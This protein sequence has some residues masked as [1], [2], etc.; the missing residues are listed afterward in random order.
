MKRITSLLLTICL[1]VCTFNMC[2][3]ADGYGDSFG[4]VDDTLPDIIE[5]DFDPA[6]AVGYNDFESISGFTS[7]SGFVLEDCGNSAY[8]KALR[9]SAQGWG[10]PSNILNATY[11]WNGKTQKVFN[12]TITSGE[13]YILS[14]EYWSDPD[15]QPVEIGDK[16][17]NPSFVIGGPFS[18]APQHANLSNGSGDHLDIPPYFNDNKWHVNTF[19]FTADATTVKGKINSCATYTKSYFDN[20]LLMKAGE[21]KIND[22]TNT[23]Y[24]EP[25]KGDIFVQNNAKAYNKKNTAALGSEI[26]FKLPARNL[27]VNV[28]EVKMGNAV[29]TPDK[30]GVYNVKITDD[31]V[32]NVE[33]DISFITDKF[34]VDD[35]NNIY[36]SDKESTISFINAVN[37]AFNMFDVIR[38]DE[39]PAK[40]TWLTANDKLRLNLINESYNVKYIGDVA[41]GGDGEWTVSDVLST[42]SNILGTEETELSEASFDMNKTGRTTVSDVVA[43]RS[44]ILNVPK[45]LTPDAELIDTMDAFFQDVLTRSGTGATEQDLINGIYN[46]GDRTRIANV[47]RKAMRGEQI[48]V[49]YFGGSITNTSGGSSVAPFANSITETGGYVEWITRWFKKHFGENSIDAFNA[50]IGSTDT[51]LAIHRMVEDVLEKEPDLVINEWSMNDSA[52]SAFAYKQG[53]YEAVVKRLLENDIAVLLYGFAGSSGYTSEEVHKPVADYYSVPFVSEK[54]A[55]YH[56]SNFSKFTNDDVHPNMVGHALTGINMTYFLQKVYEEINVIGTEPLKLPDIYFHSEAHRYEGAYMVDLYDAYQAGEE[57][58]NGVVIKDMG[59]FEFDTTKTS[60]GIGG[61]RSYYGA[62]AKLAASYKPMVIEIKSAKTL[63]LLTRIFS[64]IEDGGYY[65]E[66]NG[67]KMTN[68]EY[69]CSKGKKQDTN[70]EAGYHW[71]TPLIMYDA[72]SPSVE[73]KIYPNM[74][75][76]D[77]NNKVTIFSL[78]LS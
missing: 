70:P 52:G 54:S 18:F 33:T 42:I 41:N 39:Q 8:G 23:I 20:Y 27:G 50:G 15:P 3:L 35:N 12:E 6:Y 4:N 34:A 19:A 55:F 21:I 44:K 22:D 17:Y 59:S 62:T 75:T 53:T 25:V 11:S 37:G 63:F 5:R 57:G 7:Q 73:L 74:L 24:L 61:F 46:Y 71:P 30:D 16:T 49:V 38:G 31:I 72:D 60:F 32:V 9:V 45:A 58:L 43:L 13:D 68:T 48:K 76:N 26:S 10:V 77:A 40:D 47:I 2:A 29:L 78:L 28:S 65:I 14:Y 66:L 1:I 56:L 36:F 67:E 51:P 69:N 64:G